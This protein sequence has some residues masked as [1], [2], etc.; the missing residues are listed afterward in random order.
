MEKLASSQPV[1]EKWWLPPA[2]FRAVLLNSRVIV[3]LPVAR[4]SDC[5]TQALSSWSLSL[6]CLGC[7]DTIAGKVHNLSRR[8]WQI[9]DSPDCTSRPGLAA[10]SSCNKLRKPRQYCL[11]RFAIWCWLD[12]ARSSTSSKCQWSE[13]S[14]FIVIRIANDHAESQLHEICSY[15]WI[16][17][18]LFMSF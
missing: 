1:V 15:R 6:C 12:H 14:F 11:G 5:I 3:R 13:P 9:V 7:R 16:H 17:E 4:A 10:L 18:G 2:S 8:C